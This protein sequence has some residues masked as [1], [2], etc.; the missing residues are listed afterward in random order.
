MTNDIREALAAGD[1]ERFN[2]LNREKV[3]LAQQLGS[4]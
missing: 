4:A 3:S 2:E 1:H